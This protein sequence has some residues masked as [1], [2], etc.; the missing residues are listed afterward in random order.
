M[1]PLSITASTLTVLAALGTVFRLVRTY[2]GA[3]GQLEALNNEVS[4]TTVA[5][6]DVARILKE[7]QDK[8]G[9][10]DGEGSHLALALSNICQKAGRLEALFRSCI[11]PPTSTS[12]GIR[13]S[14]I[15]WLKVKSKV[16]HLQ[17]ELRDGRLK[18]LVALAT[19]TA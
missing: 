8:N 18:L 7:Y 16:P 14:R 17:T 15:S 1:D 11:N 10:L 5:V 12:D 9:V 2:R 6:R 3:P 13:F 4:N 19:L